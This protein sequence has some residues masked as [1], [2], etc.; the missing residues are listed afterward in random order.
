[1]TLEWSV[2]IPFTQEAIQKDVPSKA[3]VYQF[4]QTVHYWLRFCDRWSRI[5]W[6]SYPAQDSLSHP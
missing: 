3:G 6:N 1:M 5:G 2:E 4:L